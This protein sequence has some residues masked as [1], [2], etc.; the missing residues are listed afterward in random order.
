M[1]I[2]MIIVFLIGYIAIAFEHTLNTN[3]AAPALL[4]CAFMWTLYIFYAPTYLPT[5]EEFQHFA[6]DPSVAHLTSFDK[7]ISYVTTVQIIE[8]IGDVSEILFFLMG[9]MTIVEL[10]DVHGGFNI[11]TSRITTKKKKK[12]LWLLTG[13]TFIMSAILDNLTTSI[14]MVMLLRKLIANYKERWL[15]ACIIIIAANSGG[16][17]SPIGDVTTIMLWVKGNVTTAG[18]LPN[19]ILPSIISVL[20]PVAIVSRFLKGDLTSKREVPQNAGGNHL[21]T[22]R[23]ITTKEQKTIFFLGVG[24]LIFVPIFKSITHLPPFIGVLL[25]LGVLWIYTEILY[26]KKKQI[27][28]HS[29]A[30]ISVVLGRI[31]IVTILFFLGILMAVA[32]LQSAGILHEFSIFLAEKIGDVYLINILIGFLSSVVDNVPLVAGAMGMYPLANGELLADP[33]WMN[34]AQDGIFWLF[35]AYCAGVGGSM[36]II[37][38]AAGV[39][40]MGL[41]RVNFVWYF[42]NI[43][44]L[45]ALGYLAGAGFF[46]I[47]EVWLRPL[48]IGI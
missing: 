15:F 11:I 1:V 16:A 6:A 2:L 3:K 23:Y 32:V 10:I 46:Y 38:S 37:G 28:E 9:A 7:I 48:L 18:L 31:D 45:A 20:I 47:Q 13:I 24:S 14:V 33:Y 41:E 27:P 40:V 25:G 43:S 5:T 39:V 35:L 34:F 36:L 19:L 17:F 29:K 4:L 26:Q 44:F 8:H 22:V 30:R 42:K 21:D 12:L